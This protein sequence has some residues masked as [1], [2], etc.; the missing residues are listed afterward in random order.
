M[1]TLTNTEYTGN[2]L[3]GVK[4]PWQPDWIQNSDDV[5]IFLKLPSKL[6]LKTSCLTSLSD[7]SFF[8]ILL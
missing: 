3:I 4:H 6:P 8:I 1:S 5:D 7:K 2:G